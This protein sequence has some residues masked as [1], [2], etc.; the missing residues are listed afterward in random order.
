MSKGLTEEFRKITVS[1]NGAKVLRRLLPKPK[2]RRKVPVPA[3]L[4]ESL[5]EVFE[6]IQ[7]DSHIRLDY[8]DAI[9]VGAVCGGRYGKKP[10]SYVLT[11]YPE[12]DVERGR[13]FLTF[14][15]TEIE[16]IG[17][18]RM[19]EITLYCCT[20]PECRCKFREADDHCFYCDYA[21]DPNYG[22]LAFP[23]AAAKLAERGVPGVAEN[24]TKESVA[25]VLGA[26]DES[27][28]GTKHPGLGYVW[29]WIRYRRP[30]CQLRFEFNKNGTQV[31]SV[32]IM[33][34]DW[35]PGK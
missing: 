1:R 9:Q 29:P 25:A 5:H 27:G 13:W 7:Q 35:E 34:K 2:D 11:Y 28:G 12:G 17:D 20:S 33:E 10:R 21:D 14:D 23:D 15:R 8:D 4:R 16:D 26:P 19:G 32:T 18:G 3:E 22:T 30:D 6:L 31:R 24:S